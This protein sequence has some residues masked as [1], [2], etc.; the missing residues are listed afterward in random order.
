M[1]SAPVSLINYKIKYKVTDKKRYE[2]PLIRECRFSRGVQLLAG[3]TG[4]PE[5]PTEED[6]S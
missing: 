5:G 2:K 4:M 3:S 1:L 6:L